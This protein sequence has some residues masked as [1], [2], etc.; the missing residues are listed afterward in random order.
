MKRDKRV[1]W[2]IRAGNSI[3]MAIVLCSAISA[4]DAIGVFCNGKGGLESEL[5]WNLEKKGIGDPGKKFFN[6]YYTVADDK[7][8]KYL[9]YFS[10]YW[11]F[12]FF[13]YTRNRST[14]EWAPYKVIQKPKTS[15]TKEKHLFYHVEFEIDA[16]RNGSSQV[17]VQMTANPYDP[18]MNMTGRV[19]SKGCSVESEKDSNQGCKWVEFAVLGQPS[20]W[21]CHCNGKV[22]DK[23]KCKP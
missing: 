7:T 19:Y 16:P 2:L 6:Y 22:A 10:S 20:I 13:A 23:S 14:E 11:N 18:L 15:T 3:V 9:F 5:I 21:E 8:G 17:L 4:N 12:K 1:H